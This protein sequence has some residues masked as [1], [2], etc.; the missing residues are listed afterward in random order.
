MLRPL[1]C[2]LLLALAAPAQTTWYVDVAGVPPGTGTFAD[3][4]TSI[5]FALQQGTTLGGDTVLVAPGT[6]FESVTFPGRGVSVIATGGSEATAIDSDGSGSTVTFLSTDGGTMVL[7]GFTIRGGTGTSP[8]GFSGDEQG[9]GILA[10]S[11]IAKVLDCVIEDNT[12]FEGGGAYASNSTFEMRRTI[13]RNNTVDGF[14]PTGAGLMFSG[15]DAVLR[16]CIIQFNIA[17]T[18]SQPG[19]GG[20]IYATG[21]LSMQRCAVLDNRAE[22]AGGGIHGSVDIAGCRITRNTSQFGGGVYGSSTIR[23]SA[24]QGNRA[25]SASGSG[26]FGGGVY[27]ASTLTNCL[28]VGNLAYGQGGGADGATLVRCTLLDNEARDGDNVNAQGAGAIAS[29][30][31]D[32]ILTNNVAT[33]FFGAVGG[34]ASQSFLTGCVLTANSAQ[35]SFPPQA[36]G[37]GAFFCV[38]DACTVLDNTTNGLGGGLYGG[39]SLA[40]EIVG[41]DAGWGGGAASASLERST[42]FANSATTGAGGVHVEAYAI[43]SLLDSIV[44]LN[45]STEI[46]VDA[47]GSLTVTYTDVL[48]GW[49]GLGNLDADPLFWNEGAQDVHLQALSPCIDAGDPASALDPDGSRADMGAYPFDPNYPNE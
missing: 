38:L 8:S 36:A 21:P 32:C 6:Y 17:G 40:C 9:G 23:Q 11:S 45:G 37:G 33:G 1:A 22:L 24:L 12:A 41:N 42:L 18:P 49:P 46:A 44:W 10:S 2:L 48:G 30:L 31:T 15:G 35:C 29:T 34:G 4:F 47:L 39:S 43:G 16:R 25:D 20:G 27:G 19:M 14:V 26:H 7:S 28:L 13:V 3:P 5:D